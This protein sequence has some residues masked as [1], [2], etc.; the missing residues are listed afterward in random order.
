MTRSFYPLCT[1]LL[2]TSCFYKTS[3][4]DDDDTGFGAFDDT[5]DSGWST[6]QVAA[7]CEAYLACLADVQPDAVP[8][9]LD[10]YGDGSECWSSQE[11]HDVCADACQAALDLMADAFPDSEACG[12]SSGGDPDVSVSWGSSVI[13]VTISGGSEDYWLGIVET[14]GCGSECWTGEDCVWG[15][16]A[17]STTLGPYCH[18]MGKTG[19]SLAYGGDAVELSPGETVFPDSS[20]SDQVT[21]YLDGDSSA[22]CWIW[23][24]DPGYYSALGCTTV[25][26]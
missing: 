6:G 21:Y 18:D 25:S 16:S 3:D 9:T 14:A 4:D 19:D 13:Q 24:D 12:G 26:W 11:N 22:S 23:G 7:E 5:G 10:A 2:V 20:F 15:F 1:I 8:A 17:G